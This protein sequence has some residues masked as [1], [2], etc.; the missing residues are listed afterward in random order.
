MWGVWGSVSTRVDASPSVIDCD[1]KYRC[2]HTLDISLDTPIHRLPHGGCIFVFCLVLSVEDPLTDPELGRWSPYCPPLRPLMLDGSC[3]ASLQVRPPHC[4]PSSPH[5]LA[6][7]SSTASTQRSDP[8]PYHSLPHRPTHHPPPP[9]I[10]RASSRDSPPP[11][12]PPS[13]PSSL[14][15]P[16]PSS[17]RYSIRHLDAIFSSSLPHLLP[18]VSM[19]Y[20]SSRCSATHLP[21]RSALFPSSCLRRSLTPRCVSCLRPV[22]GFLSLL[23]EGRLPKTHPVGTEP[24]PFTFHLTV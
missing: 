11:S 20:P 12:A 3:T 2:D 14:P 8:R 6:L 15:S 17:P 24:Q 21:P 10:L 9:S 13:N 19:L 5:W 4:S 22:A 16:S 18:F 1:R 7:P 23:N